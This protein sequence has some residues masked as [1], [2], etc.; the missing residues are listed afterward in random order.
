MRNPYYKA[1]DN[2]LSMEDWVLLSFDAHQT[3]LLSAF[4]ASTEDHGSL[5]RV[6]DLEPEEPDLDDFDT[7]EEYEAA[8]E[9]W[10]AELEEWEIRF[11]EYYPFAWGTFWS[12]DDYRPDVVDALVASGF[13]VYDT[14]GCM[15]DFGA[16]IFGVNGGGYSFYGA[17]WCPLRVRLLINQYRNGHLSRDDFDRAVSPIIR[18]AEETG[19]G[20]SIRKL[21][22]DFVESSEDM[23]P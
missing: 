7:E 10:E 5:N 15:E 2:T 4:I 20:E 8:I 1:S 6:D 16:T 19:E 18:K 11:D 13:V 17:H 14:T 12:L 3:S 22:R 23:A 9:K 21:V